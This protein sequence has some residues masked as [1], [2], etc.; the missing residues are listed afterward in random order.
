MPSFRSRR[1]VATRIAKHSG[2][3]IRRPHP[4]AALPLAAP[5]AA[6]ASAVPRPDAVWRRR[7]V[8]M[9]R[10]PLAGRVKTRLAR[11]IGAVS[12]ARFYRNATSG[13]I[14]RLDGDRRWQL[15]LA[16]TP[17]AAAGDGAWPAR[18]PRVAQRDGDLGAR[19]Q[20]LF[21]RLPPGPVVVI[22]SDSP[23]VSRRHIADAFRSLGSTDAVLGPA[24]DGGYWLIGMKRLGRMPRPF[25]GVRWSSEHTLA[26][27]LANLA[28]KRV[29][30]L[31]LLDDVDEP[32][33]LARIGDCVGRRI[34][35][36]AG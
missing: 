15:T 8:M 10:K 3:R 33:D 19:L 36:L 1:I 29:G 13:L 21:E 17:D 25:A 4:P 5:E 6:P 11:G 26:D 16:V 32:A 2:Q 28:G 20:R 35:T 9:V 30:R 27:T 7:L 14:A 18:L 31:D 23:Q 22:G 24:S 34:A 12:A